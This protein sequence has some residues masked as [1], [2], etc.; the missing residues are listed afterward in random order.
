[1]ALAE[2]RFA[3]SLTFLENAISCGRVESLSVLGVRHL[4]FGELSAA[5]AALKSYLQQAGIGRM[6]RTTYSAQLAFVY[7]VRADFS[8][9]DALLGA[10]GGTENPQWRA[11][12]AV[13][14]TL[15]GNP[16]RAAAALGERPEGLLD[17]PGLRASFAGILWEAGLHE[18]ARA[19]V[20][21]WREGVAAT[22]LRGLAAGSELQWGD[23]PV[24]NQVPSL[25][26]AGPAF[27]DE[28][29]RAALVRI[30]QSEPDITA[31][32]VAGATGWC[33]Q[34]VYGDW[35]VAFDMPA[36]AER[37]YH[38]AL[39]WCLRERCPI[40]GGR[41][42]Q[43]LA[44]IAARNRDT[45]A[46]FEHLDRA[47]DLFRKHGAKLYLDQVIA[48]KVELQGLTFE[49]MHSSIVAINAAV[50]SVHPDL[51]QQAAPDGTVTLLFSDIENSTPL[52]EQLGDAKWME[53][54]RAHNAII[55]AEVKAHHGYVVKTMGDGYMVAF[56]GAADGLRCAIAIQ[57]AM[58][59]RNDGLR[60]RI[61]L[62]TGEMTRAGDDFFGRHVNLAARVAGH[63]VGGEVL[64]SGVVHE[65]VAGQG[66]TFVD[67]GERTMK[68]F[69]E[70]VRVWAV[71][72]S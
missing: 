46:A 49:D 16:D 24:W 21:G 25:G 63:A 10:E 17:A 70:P 37:L 51:R 4:R 55:D 31:T 2:G 39:E 45:T 47:G 34:R 41:C 61:G 27:A 42:H 32:R 26:G 44:A 19:M 18:G 14:E 20:Q 67:G 35:A 33:A 7:L 52:N 60:V 71:R 29:E 23:V 8:A 65:L 5:E 36:D 50:Q 69:E 53:L 13:R 3:D 15:G 68:G 57:E 66:F 64:V 28:G 48:K 22:G 6:A 72:W 40:E 11:A 9:F 62:H 38:D 30:V 54:L 43:G 56:K 12:L 59:G 1:M 58:T